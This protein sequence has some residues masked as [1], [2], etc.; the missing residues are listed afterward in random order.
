M[1]IQ[2]FGKTKDGKQTFLYLLE[3][4][5]G[6]KAAV[7]DYGANL[8]RLIV[9][10]KTGKEED[11]VLGFDDVSGYEN[12]PSFFGALIAPNANRIKD[13]SFSLDGTTYL[14]KKNNGENNLHTDEALGAHK[15]IW[16]AAVE[17]ESVCFTLHMEDGE[18][19]LPGNREMKVTYS[20][21][22]EN[23]LKITYEASSDKPTIF[24][25]TNHS[26]FNLKG[27]G[28][29][30]ITDHEMVLHA[31]AYVPIDGG[32]IPTGAIEL[33][34]G[35]PM[36]L[37]KPIRIGERIDEDFGALKFAGGYDHNWITDHWDQR[38]RRIAVA[39]AP[40]ELRTM[41]VYTDLPGVQFY[42]GNFIEEQQ[43][44]EG[45]TYSKR[46][47][48]CLETQYFP[49]SVNKPHFP[50]TVFGG[51]RIYTSCTIFK[52]I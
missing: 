25:L 36:D 49:D 21:S 11:V 29:G 2:E 17:E 8:V 44:K 48:F 30:D 42:A 31:T 9:A 47:G 23:E 19:G 5:Q 41:E 26:Y 14:L 3:N 33:V 27:H 24:N 4:K 34:E 10:D 37:R 15:R 43:G 40:Q 50:S 45:A 38:I 16:S 12:N 22:E 35:T 20:L 46:S 39:K 52:F 32:L 13:A 28:K 1:K 51:E 18:L 6:M 7:T